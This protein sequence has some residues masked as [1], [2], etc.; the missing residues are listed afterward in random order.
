[1]RTDE[2]MRELWFPLMKGGKLQFVLKRGIPF[3]LLL[4]CGEALVQCFFGAN[5][6]KVSTALVVFPILAIVSGTMY[7]IFNWYYLRRRYRIT[8][9]SDFGTHH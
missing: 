9:E 4:A 2:E 7:G 1:M 6:M 3:G 5:H 8:F